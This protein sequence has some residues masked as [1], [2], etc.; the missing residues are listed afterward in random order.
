MGCNDPDIPKVDVCAIASDGLICPDSRMNNTY[1]QDFILSRGWTCV[2]P[3]D[4]EEISKYMI[5]LYYDLQ[6]CEARL[7]AK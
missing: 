7:K 2:D 1:K 5:D 4:Y 6:K 3:D